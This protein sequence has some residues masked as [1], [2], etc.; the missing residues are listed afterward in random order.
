M[1]PPAPSFCQNVST[2][3]VTLSWKDSV[4][5]LSYTLIRT[6]PSKTFTP[7][8][9]P[10]IDSIGLI[11]GIS[12][13]WKVQANGPP[14]VLPTLS[15]SK[16]LPVDYCK[17]FQPVLTLTPK[18]GPSGAYMSLAWSPADV[19][20][21]TYKVYR[22]D[23]L[24][25]TLGGRSW[26]DTNNGGGL[27]DNKSYTYR[28]KASGPTL[29]NESTDTSK[30]TLFCATPSQPQN[31][32]A[33][34]QCVGSNATIP[35]VS[36]TWD[37]SSN[38]TYYV[39]T[40]VLNSLPI[41]FILGNLTSYF[42]NGINAGE[43]NYLYYVVAKN[44][45]G[46][47]PQSQSVLVNPD[48]N[49]KYYCKP[50]TPILNSSNATC[51]NAAP[52]NTL[53][54]TDPIQSDTASYNIYRGVS[55]NLLKTINSGTPEFIS[56]AWQDT[57][58]LN[59]STLYS[60]WIKAIGPAGQ[61]T[62]SAPLPITTANCATLPTPALKLALACSNNFPIPTLS[63]DNI[64]G[65]LSYDLSR[66]NPDT[67]VST[68]ATIN[69]PF[70]DN[71][72]FALSFNG[73]NN[74]VDAA[75]PNA[76]N[77]NSNMSLFAWVNL[78]DTSKNQTIIE[79]ANNIGAGVIGSYYMG[80]SNVTSRKVSIFW[81]NTL[82]D[83]SNGALQ[84]N[85]W[86]LI[87]FTRS[88]ST[89][90]WTNSIYIN[91]ALDKQTTTVTNPVTV[92]SQS[93]SIG[94]HNAA[95]PIRFVSGSIDDTRIYSRMLNSD[96]VSQLYTQGSSGNELGLKG[97][98]NFNEG[99]GATAQDTSGNGNNGTIVGTPVWV[100]PVGKPG[101]GAPLDNKLQYTYKLKALG[102]GNV[103]PASQAF[104]PASTSCLPAKP[105]VSAAPYSQDGKKQINISWH[106]DPNPINTLYWNIY[107]RQVGKSFG[108]VVPPSPVASPPAPYIDSNVTSGISY[109]YFVS[110]HGP[111]A[112]IS[113]TDSDLTP[114]IQAPFCQN[115]PAKPVFTPLTPVARCL[116]TSPR[117]YMSWG[118]DSTGNTLAY[119]IYRD[120][121]DDS[122]TKNA[123]CTVLPSDPLECW[124]KN[125]AANESHQY[126]I[127][128]LGSGQ[129][130]FTKSDISSPDT[131][132]NDCS[133]VPPDP[134]HIVFGNPPVSSIA[135]KQTV[136]LEWQDVGNADQYQIFR[137][138]EGETTFALAPWWEKL[139][140]KNALADFANPLGTRIG[141]HDGATKIPYPDN[142]PA[143]AT[144]YE[145]LVRAINANGLTDS[146]VTNPGILVPIG[147]PGQFTLSGSPSNLAWTAADT[148]PAGGPVTYTVYRDVCATFNTPPDANPPS[149]IPTAINCPNANTLQPDMLYH[150]SDPSPS[151]RLFYKVAAQNN[152]GKT[153]SNTLNLKLPLPTY[154]EMPP[155]R[156]PTP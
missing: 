71:G 45:G 106:D 39:L 87:G 123:T 19:N 21:T 107:K 41:N 14:G 11:P 47:S 82:I 139:F 2:P 90:S 137:R 97:F 22:N 89:G 114:A 149:C 54:W 10:Y 93:F 20:V 142:S 67:S 147:T 36:I 155:K 18:C 83:T 108:L 12:S 51:K 13:T 129:G 26:D 61:S 109:E 64:T 94:R 127:K 86:Y 110:A 148:S 113:P 48:S 57:I 117:I 74:Y 34:F 49:T 58:S 152:G 136:W 122:D 150:C 138:K 43:S 42:D 95:I 68:Y 125:V 154:K 4:N 115:I 78:V 72:D 146:N 37:P 103:S 112:G 1:D 25:K 91:G 133:K 99:Q 75:S 24:I 111:N 35:R 116:G 44:A 3:A 56:R 143:E 9:S 53:T 59:P 27:E 126:W 132:V 28:I 62:L 130:N 134:P 80:V 23:D 131:I 145:Y 98:W 128:A 60:Y 52:A 119:N 5:A 50:S 120:L 92:A 65:A 153:D 100:S 140:F 55:N 118:K 77:I 66:T 38:V 15:N 70:T 85:T 33:Q 16:T 88:G 101:Y 17:P 79:E 63:W 7:V 32:Q 121:A 104:V 102:T 69:S 124:D 84:N 81:N 6:N 73:V 30:R 135:S 8:T 151:G 141:T 105:D 156:I 76:L 31:V 29:S 46:S 96:E 40:R 144:K